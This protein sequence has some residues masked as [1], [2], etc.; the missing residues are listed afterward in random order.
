MN[1]CT[2]ILIQILHIYI[3]NYKNPRLPN[4]FNFFVFVNEQIHYKGSN[5]KHNQYIEVVVNIKENLDRK[6]DQT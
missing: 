3:Q 2:E 6:V 1:F 4:S 5:I